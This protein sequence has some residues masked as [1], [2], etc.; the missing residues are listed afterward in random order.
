MIHVDPILQRLRYRFQSGLPHLFPGALCR[1]EDAH[2]VAVTIDDGPSETTALLLEQL[3]QHGIIATFFLT[4]EA[5]AKHP[6][7][8]KSIVEHGHAI[9]SHGYRHNDLA[10]QPR[11]AVKTDLELS[12]NGIESETGIRPKY[13]RPPYGRLNPLHRHI[14]G[15]FGCQLVL[16][17]RLPGDFDASVSEAELGKRIGKI[18]DGDIIV[19]HDLAS[20]F[21]RSAAGLAFIAD[22]LQRASLKAVT[23]S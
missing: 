8:V 5:V 12:L 7:H 10:R 18:Q 11:E 2:S 20:S 4:G 22:L 13:Y 16:W 9:G 3:S 15:E 6:A 14:P 1:I 19:L 21:D 17:N 23:L